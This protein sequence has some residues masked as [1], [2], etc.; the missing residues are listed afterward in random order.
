MRLK[1][2]QTFKVRAE[3]ADESAAIE[4]ARNFLA[5]SL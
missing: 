2:G 1:C 4:A 5:E 3:G